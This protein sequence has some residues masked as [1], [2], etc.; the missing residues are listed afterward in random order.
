MPPLQIPQKAKVL[1]LGYVISS[2]LLGDGKFL[3]YDYKYNPHEE[4]AVFL[5][6]RLSEDG[7][8]QFGHE[9]C[10]TV[11][12]IPQS[13]LCLR[14]RSIT[15]TNLQEFDFY[16]QRVRKTVDGPFVS[17]PPEGLGEMSGLPNVMTHAERLPPDNPLA[18]MAYWN[19]PGGKNLTIIACLEWA[20][21]HLEHV[22]KE[23]PCEE[24]TCA[25][26]SLRSALECQQ[27]RRQRRME[28][29]LIGTMEPHK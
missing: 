19:S 18:D 7:T 14:S 4:T 17:V 25:I 10:R 29:G 22:N 15:I 13:I 24:N 11:A 3:V 9:N 27:Q 2:P 21:T 8:Y 12:N 16:E 23:L 26:E 6:V 20:L 28:Q 1:S 5:L